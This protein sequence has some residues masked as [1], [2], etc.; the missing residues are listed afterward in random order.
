VIPAA[1]KQTTT[2]R[3]R[4]FVAAIEPLLAQCG[5]CRRA[6]GSHL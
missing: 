5:W 4:R 6:A 2:G 1:N 3:R